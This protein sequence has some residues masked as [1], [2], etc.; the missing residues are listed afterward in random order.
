MLKFKYQIPVLKGQLRVAGHKVC[1]AEFVSAALIKVPQCLSRQANRTGH[2]LRW[3]CLLK[4]V[5]E[6]K[7]EGRIACEWKTRKK[8]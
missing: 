4:H 3:K 5:V 6:G 1:T 8:T 7:V 2:I